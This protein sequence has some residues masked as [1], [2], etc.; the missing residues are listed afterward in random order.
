MKAPLDS[1]PIQSRQIKQ[2][3]SEPDAYFSSELGKVVQDLPPLYTRLVAASISLAVFGTIAWL[4]FSK[5]DEV[6]VAPGELIPSDP[7]QPVRAL[8]SGIVLSIKVNEGQ[9]VQK[10]DVLIEYDSEQLQAQ[11][12]NLK[13]QAELIRADLSRAG[14]AEAGGQNARVNEA[15]IELARLQENLK[16]TKIILSNAQQKEASLRQLV[17]SR[18]VTRLDYIEAKNQVT[19]AEDRAISQEKNIVAQQQKIEQLREEYKSG[20]LSKLSQR[21]EELKNV[22]RQLYQTMDRL[23]QD[24]IVAPIAGKVYNLNVNPTKGTVQS[25]EELVSILP[26]GKEPLLVVDLPNQYRGFVNEGMQA[27]IK[28]DAFPYQEFGVVDGT[29]IY[30]SPNAVTKDGKKVFPAKIKPHKLSIRAQG[31]DKLLTPGMTAT[32][33]IVMRQRTVLSLLIEPITQKFDETFQ[34]K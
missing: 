12:N 32:G 2:Q 24:S 13:Q 9:Q 19:E 27:K 7:V 33:E 3:F 4:S 16:S 17:A 25:G 22:E 29:V 30:V 8:N 23:K 34:R 14:K 20:N 31:Q 18:A 11:V 26:E 10:G 28:V 5:V 15:E 6:A 21:R 1:S